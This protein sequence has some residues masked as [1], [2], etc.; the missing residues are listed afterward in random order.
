MPTAT[1]QT[2]TPTRRTAIGFSLAAFAA[3]LATPALA[4]T[5]TKPTGTTRIADLNRQL[6]ALSDRHSELDT[7]I[8]RMPEPKGPEWDAADTRLDQLLDEGLALQDEIMKFPRRTWRM[9]R[10]RSLSVIT[11]PTRWMMR[12]SGR[13]CGRCMQASYWPS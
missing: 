13:K 5:T 1:K 4:S 8:T 11:D 6:R 12:I 7:A 10:Y 9:Q 3:G 2:T